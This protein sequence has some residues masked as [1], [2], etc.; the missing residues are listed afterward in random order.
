MKKEVQTGVDSTGKPITKVYN[1]TKTTT[2]VEEIGTIRYTF[3]VRGAYYNNNISNDI[4]IKNTVN[5]VKYSGEVPPSSEYR[6]SDNKALGSNE[7]KKKVEE[8]LKKE[9]N[10]HIDSMVNDLKRI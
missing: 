5:N 10:G 7:L 8:K 2:T 3:S 1:F 4:T 6:N 9:V